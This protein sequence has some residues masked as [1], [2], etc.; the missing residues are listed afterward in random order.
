MLPLM[1]RLALPMVFS[2]PNSQA[3]TQVGEEEGNRDLS[4]VGFFC[5][6]EVD[7]ICGGIVGKVDGNRGGAARFCT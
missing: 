3:T 2:T 4:K 1:V 6:G 5:V 7:E